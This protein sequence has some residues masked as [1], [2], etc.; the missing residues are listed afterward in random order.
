MTTE[1]KNL[2]YALLGGAAVVGA[3]VLYY[4]TS[5][6]ESKN[7]AGLAEQEANDD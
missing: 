6:G 5:S 3:A 4:M 2:K 7:E 1:N